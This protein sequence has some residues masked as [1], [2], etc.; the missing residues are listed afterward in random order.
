MVNNL[1]QQELK[2]IKDEDEQTKLLELVGNTLLPE[3][4]YFIGFL[5]L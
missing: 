4:N 2:N 3:E 5:P 1:S